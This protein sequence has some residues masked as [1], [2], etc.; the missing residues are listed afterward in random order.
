MA[1]F[2]RAAS[3]QARYLTMAE[4]ALRH[5]ALV[6]AHLR[7]SGFDGLVIKWGDE[8][9]I[10]SHDLSGTNSLFDGADVVRFVSLRRMNDDEARN[11]DWVG[12]DASGQVTAFIPRR[13]LAQMQALADRGFLQRDGDTLLGGVNLGSIAVSRR[14]LD[15]LLG[16]FEHDV[17]DPGASRR[18]RPDLDPQFFTA[19]C[20][21]CIGDDTVRATAWHIALRETP[22]LEKLDG[23]RLDLFRRLEAVVARFRTEHAEAPR[24]VAMDFGEPYWGD[25]GQHRQIREF[26][27]ALLDPGP[28]G[29]IARALA[30]I[31]SAPD[32][33]G[34]RLVDCKLPLGAQVE[35]SVLIG[36]EI[37][38]GCDVRE[39]VL[40]GTRAGQVRGQG[41]FDVDSVVGALQLAPGAGSYRVVDVKEVRVGA[42]ERMTS[43]FCK[44]VG[45]APLHLRVN[46]RT[47]LRQ[48]EQHYDV[49][50]LGNAISFAEAHERASALDPD[51]LAERREAQRALVLTRLGD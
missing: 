23:G 6:E 17:N 19:L 10:S 39:C 33:R 42:S 9:Q 51:E 45:Q 43:L 11:K 20:I 50:I 3:G 1:S 22:S 44:P 30:G 35:N 49:P 26:Y 28:E 36:C 21:A 4:L 37:T 46:E 32:E 47:D 16:E 29:E 38:R 7:R 2:V 34:N 13:P 8:V 48:R 15:A 25:I 24:V 27:M 18:E 31:D 40:V 41:A 14:L 12:V 5:F